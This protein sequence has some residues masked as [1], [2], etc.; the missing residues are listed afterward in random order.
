MS[1]EVE[2]PSNPPNS[3]LRSKWSV[4]EC[5]IQM[6]KN[7]KQ[8]FQQA[9]LHSAY[10]CVLCVPTHWSTNEIIWL[11]P[12]W[13]WRVRK[14]WKRSSWNSNNNNN[15]NLSTVSIT[16]SYMKWTLLPLTLNELKMEKEKR[17]WCG[18]KSQ[19]DKNRKRK[20]QKWWREGGARVKV[21]EMEHENG[22]LINGNLVLDID[23]D[24]DD[25][26]RR[27]CGRRR[28]RTKT[29]IGMAI[30]Q[31]AANGSILTYTYL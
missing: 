17:K 6:N 11:R 24:D 1:F 10:M 20:A 7:P 25:T 22:T 16:R 27:K 15:K 30:G 23:A 5:N 8:P 3:V 2:Q 31:M 18:Q 26:E 21:G 19:P 29:T 28:T 12:V 13:R 4:P 9:Q 14:W